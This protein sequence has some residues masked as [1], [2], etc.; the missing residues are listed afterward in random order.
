MVAN[1]L[2]SSYVTVY[3]YLYAFNIIFFSNTLSDIPFQSIIRPNLTDSTV[4]YAKH[5]HPVIVTRHTSH[6]F[7]NNIASV[8]QPVAVSYS[9]AIPITFF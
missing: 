6:V 5:H 1:N 2:G 4:E 8:A 9:E 3:T 7:A